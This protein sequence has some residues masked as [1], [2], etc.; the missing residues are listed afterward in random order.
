MLTTHP[1]S[2]EQPSSHLHDQEEEPELPQKVESPIST[3]K[4]NEEEIPQPTTEIM[5][6]KSS[7]SS[8][9]EVLPTVESPISTVK[10]NEEEISQPTT[11][12]M[13]EKS[14]SS[15]SVEVLPTPKS[16]ETIPHSSQVYKPLRQTDAEVYSE[17]MDLHE[18]ILQHEPERKGVDT[19]PVDESTQDSAEKVY[20]HL[21]L[22]LVQP[23]VGLVQPIP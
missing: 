18:L 10:E 23:T 13:D 12:I 22:G 7:S 9:V 17:A 1:F 16:R 2:A 5:D 3:V 21:R 15:S 19:Q 6:E 20:L 8:S 4:D 14:S 11:K